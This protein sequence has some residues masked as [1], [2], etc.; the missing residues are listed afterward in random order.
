MPAV[1]LKELFPNGQ[2]ELD[3]HLDVLVGGYKVDLWIG[4]TVRASPD[5]VV[6]IGRKAVAMTGV[7]LDGKTF[8]VLGF[9]ERIWDRPPCCPAM[10]RYN[11]ATSACVDL[12]GSY[13]FMYFDSSS[14]TCKNRASATVVLGAVVLVL[15]GGEALLLL[16]DRSTWK[17]QGQQENN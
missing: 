13:W 9:S 2:N 17:G 6:V 11:L 5:N 15:V 3:L 14:N 10:F 4:D 16:L 12:C 8:G 1:L 7:I